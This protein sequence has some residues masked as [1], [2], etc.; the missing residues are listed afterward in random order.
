M[1]TLR[2]EAL[3][4]LGGIW[5]LN[6]AQKGLN[7]ITKFTTPVPPMGVCIGHIWCYMCPREGPDRHPKY[8]QI[9]SDNM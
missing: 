9:R 7:K 5:G 3:V 8:R 2:V 6:R 4:A 1:T